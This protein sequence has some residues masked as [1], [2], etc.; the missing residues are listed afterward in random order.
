[1]TPQEFTAALEALGMTPTA[2]A[3]LI[4]SNEKNMRRAA[5][6]DSDGPGPAAAYCLKAMLALAE[7]VETKDMK[8]S[9]GDSPEYRARRDRAWHLARRVLGGKYY[10]GV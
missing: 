9:E 5:E 3:K 1:M 6:P 8:E 10:A 4:G 7:L 2:F